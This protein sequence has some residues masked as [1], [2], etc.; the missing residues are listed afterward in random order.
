VQETQDIEQPVFR[1]V[2]S[3]SS[4]RNEPQ[5]RF[6]RCCA[7]LGGG[8]FLERRSMPSTDFG[9]FVG[10]LWMSSKHAVVKRYSWVT[11]GVH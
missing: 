11:V 2:C 5:S 8:Y 4:R 10:F 7:L 9:S 1:I 3:K 6:F